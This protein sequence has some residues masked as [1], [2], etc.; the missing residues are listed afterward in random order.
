MA[1]RSAAERNREAARKLKE[2]IAKQLKAGAGKGVEPACRF[3]VARIKETLNVPAPKV[4]VGLGYRATTRATVGAPPRK[5]SGRMQKGVTHKMLSGIVGLIGVH[6]RAEPTKKYPKGFNYPRY[7]ETGKED[8]E[9]R[10]GAGL[11]PYLKPTVDKYKKELRTIVGA[12]A[13]VEMRK[14]GW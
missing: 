4:K 6:A 5:L 10:L 11:H 9:G 2:R 1:R 8:G 13:K 7:H 12:E 3:L 14:G